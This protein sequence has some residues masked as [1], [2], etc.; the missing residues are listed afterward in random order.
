VQQLSTPDELY[1]RPVNSFVA[2]FIGENNTISGVVKNIDGDEALIET[3]SGEL[4]KARAV[5]ANTVGDKSTI[6]L[7]PERVVI[8][9]NAS[10]ENQFQSTVRGIIYHGDHI[11]VQVAVLGSNNFILKIPNSSSHPGVAVGDV[12]KLGWSVEDCRAL[13]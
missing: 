1:E 3:A 2:H 8:N 9:P 6:S 10:V 5:L 4:I 13:D 7:R 12:I 11:R